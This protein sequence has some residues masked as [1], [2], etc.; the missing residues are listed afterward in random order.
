MAVE[1]NRATNSPLILVPGDKPGLIRGIVKVG[2]RKEEAE[3]WTI[4]GLRDC[5]QLPGKKIVDPG[6]GK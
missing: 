2:T 3:E 5:A 1:D 4:S 6:T